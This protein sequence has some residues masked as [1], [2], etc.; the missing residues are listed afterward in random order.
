MERG[1]GGYY[2]EQLFYLD[3]TWHHHLTP[4]FLPNTEGKDTKIL[5]SRCDG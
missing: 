2:G 3:G 1:G 4:K 5:V